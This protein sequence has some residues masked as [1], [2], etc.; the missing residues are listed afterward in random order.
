MEQID[1]NHSNTVVQST[2]DPEWNRDFLERH[3]LFGH[4][5]NR[6]QNQTYY[7]FWKSQLNRNSVAKQELEKIAADINADGIRVFLLKGFSLLGEIYQD[8]GAPYVADIDLLISHDQLWRLS[9]ILKMYGYERKKETRWLGNRYKHIF[10]KKGAEVSLTIEIHT[11]LFWHTSLTMDE[12]PRMS[13]IQG[14]YQLSP[15]NQLIHLCGH[16]GFQNSFTK[17]FLMMDI[18]KYV[19]AYKKKLDWEVFW[20]NAKKA[21]LYKACFFTLFLCQKLG[22]NIQ[23]I[24]YRA[25]KHKK[26]SLSFLK[27]I[28]S[29]SYLYSPEKYPIRKFLVQF[30]IKDSLFDNLRYG[31]AWARNF[32]RK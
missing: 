4:V 22:L 12:D 7:P 3:H 16:A 19:E 13:Q 29:Y 10:V 21:N 20:K 23:P 1:V 9:D 18:F 17:L 30:L 32:L 26:M 8:W 2:K 5:Y 6:T 15:E 25:T 11:Q 28:V 14:L 24:L 31:Q 27:K